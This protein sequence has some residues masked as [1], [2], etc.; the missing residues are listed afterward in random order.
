MTLKTWRAASVVLAL[1]AV[2][3][4]GA[5]AHHS[6]SMFDSGRTVTLEGA[7]K[8]LQWTNPHVWVQLVV[9]DASGKKAEWSVEGPSANT[10]ARQGWSRAAMKPGDKAAQG[11]Q[12]RRL[13]DQR[14]GQRPAGRFPRLTRRTSRCPSRPC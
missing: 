7:V 13:A 1:A 6:F 10:L 4:T 8:Q 12:Q 11:R 2:G 14:H 3:A 9:T 5:A